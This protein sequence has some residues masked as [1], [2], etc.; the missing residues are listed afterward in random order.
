MKIRFFLLDVDYEMVDEKPI[1]RIYGITEERKSITIFYRDFYPYFYVKT[2]N[3]EK[4]IEYLEKKV[5]SL[6]V[7]VERVEKFLPIGFDPQKRILHKIYL[8]NPSKV[9]LVREDL[10]KEDFIEGIFEADILFKYRFMADFGLSGCKWYE[11]EGEIVNNTNIVYTELKFEAKKFIELEEDKIPQFK[12]LSIDIEIANE[13]GLPNPE[14]DSINIISLSFYPKFNN[15]DSLVLISKKIHFEKPEYVLCF[16]NEVEML[17]KFIEIIRTFDPDLIIGYNIN[18]FDI[19]YIINRLIKNKIKPHLGRVKKSSKSQKIGE[20]K[21]KNTITGRVIIDVYEILKEFAK[22]GMFQSKRL[23]LGDVAKIIIGRGKEEVEHS[24]I[25]KLWYGSDLDL[26]RL[27]SYAKTDAELVLEIML[28]R[29]FLSQYIEISRLSGLLLQDSFGA[30]ASRIEQFLLKEFNRNDFV[31]PNKPTKKELKEREK[32][33]IRGA[34]VLE[35]KTGLHDYVIYL[36]FKSLYPSIVIQYNICPTTYLKRKIENIEV[37]TS[38]INTYFTSKKVREGIFPRVLKKL[39]EERDKI[40]KEMKNEKDVIKKNLL[41]KKQQALKILANAFYG[42]TGYI[43]ARFFVTDIANTITAYGRY[44]ISNVKKFVEE[45]GHEVLYGDTDSIMVK[46]KANSLSEA[47]NVSNALENY[48]NSKTP[49][50]IKIKREG[51]MKRIIFLTK[52]R[53]AGYF[54]EDEDD[55]GK[56]IMKGIETVRRDWCDLV[57]ETLSKVLE[58]LLVEGNEKKAYEY[59]LEIFRNLKNNQIEIEKLAII[60]S[61]SRPINKYKGQQPH[62]ELVKKMI[63]RGETNIPGVGDRVSYVIVAGPQKIVERAES[64]EYV[65][66][67]KIPVDAEYYIYHQL[68][69]PL[70]RIF[71]AIGVSSSQFITQTKQKSILSILNQNNNGETKK[72]ETLKKSLTNEISIKNLEGFICNN[73]STVYRRIPLSGLCFICGGEII[74]YSSDSKSRVLTLEV[75]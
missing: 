36:D 10:R 35:P 44:W 15:K 46:V 65:K 3:E 71:S 16:E 64:V 69:P 25:T 45:I 66:K 55:K 27:I 33:E 67:N 21:Y 7:R 58:I 37:I 19:P 61:I 23:G 42:Y 53:Y 63:K 31:I 49:E 48:I 13:E 2:N 24:E 75:F 68:L 9:P 1:I 4:L 52:K 12:I 26:L 59:V 29:D 5:K 14:K 32:E 51:V 8:K 20:E 18:N 22:K 62:I 6:L 40:K 57:S 50:F 41:E 11:A 47:F 39:I 38:P 72:D 56:I 28:K 30:E 17:N 60:K 54:F 43:R 74:F 70:E 73:C 34:I